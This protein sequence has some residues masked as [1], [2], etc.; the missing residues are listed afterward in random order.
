MVVPKGLTSINPDFSLGKPLLTVDELQIAGAATNALHSF[1]MKL[2][3]SKKRNDILLHFKRSHFFRSLDNEFLNV[4]FSDIFDLFNYHA[5]DVF[6]LRCF[7]L[8]M[9]K[10]T[11]QM[12]LP[13][14]FLD[15]ELITL[16]TMCVD[17][18]YVVD[19]VRKALGKFAKKKC[20]M[21]A[22]NPGQHWVVVAIVPKWNKVLYLDSARSSPRDDSLLKD[23]LDEAFLSYCNT[24]GIAKNK[25]VHVNKFPFL[26]MLFTSA[27]DDNFA[28]QSL[29]VICH[30]QHPSSECGF[31]A[32]HHMNLAL[33]LLNVEK[34]EEF[35]VPTSPLGDDV[36][37][38]IRKTI[39][40]FIMS[41]VVTCDDIFLLVEMMFTSACDDISLLLQMMFTSACDD[42]FADCD[43]IVL[44]LEML[45]IL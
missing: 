21:F 17:K 37:D 2:P 9:V 7:T 30:Q 16:S 6:I 1:Y 33:A 44:L 8:H 14:G 34:A 19:Y 41:D 5:L 23:V 25:L 45:G 3:L 38:S 24:Y 15:P 42:I 12:D 18:S 39:A 26:E 22:H 35:E 11:R 4:G 31:Y 43:D 10:K 20:I 32:A 36:L 27:C 40:S 28:G 29:A 13:V